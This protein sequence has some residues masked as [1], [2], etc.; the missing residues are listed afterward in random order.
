MIMLLSYSSVTVSS[1]FDARW[2]WF[3]S[4][5][6]RVGYLMNPYYTFKTKRVDTE[7]DLEALMLI[8]SKFLPNVCGQAN[9]LGQYNFFRELG[10]AF[11]SLLA[12]T[13]VHPI[14][15]HEWFGT[16]GVAP[17][18]FSIIAMKILNMCLDQSEAERRFKRQ[19][20]IH[21]KTRN[22]MTH[23]NVR[24]LVWL[25]TNLALKRRWFKEG[26]QGFN[27]DQQQDYSWS[28]TTA[29]QT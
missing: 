26:V 8:L 20:N 13:D 17:R 1:W 10:S 12:Q 27:V 2:E 21:S 6:H 11:G 15:P 3:H 9:A 19:A 4:P 22:R 28:Q 29:R 14:P 7:E 25:S 23:E 5:V 18:P 16:F 24:N